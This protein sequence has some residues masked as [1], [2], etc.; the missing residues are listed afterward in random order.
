MDK[1]TPL[2][3]TCY[4]LNDLKVILT[5]QWL[6][7]DHLLSMKKTKRSNKGSIKEKGQFLVTKFLS[8]RSL[9]EDINPYLYIYGNG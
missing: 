1:T 3:S 6:T 2:L 5:F 9:V 4:G 8:I 7:I